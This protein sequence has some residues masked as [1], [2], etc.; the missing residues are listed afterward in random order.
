ML[1]CHLASDKRGRVA[2][3]A[4]DSTLPPQHSPKPGRPPNVPNPRDHPFAASI[5]TLQSA[6]AELNLPVAAEAFEHTSLTLLLPSG[7]FGPEPS[8][9]VVRDE[10]M[11]APVDRVSP[12]TVPALE[13]DASVLGDVLDALGNEDAGV[14]PGDTVGYWQTVVSLAG[15][16]VRGGR[17]VPHLELREDSGVAVWRALPSTAED[18]N[19]L[20]SLRGSMPPLAR[21]LVTD[22]VATR[23]EEA[24]S[25]GDADV[26]SA[27]DV[28]VRM[29]DVCVDAAVRDRLTSTEPDGSGGELDD[30]HE[31]WLAALTRPDGTI[32]A[33]PDALEDLRQQLD[34]WT[35]SLEATGEQGVRLCL[36]LWAPEPESEPESHS[37][38]D[39]EDTQVSTGDVAAVSPHGWELELLLQAADDP[40][41]LVEASTVW[42]S[43]E[44]TT[45][46]L[47]RH[48]D[49]P[50]ETLLEELGRAA[51]LYPAL[52][53]AL[54]EA[55]PTTLELTATEAN[56]FLREKAEVLEQA[57]FGVVLPAW[58]NEPERRLGAQLTAE[59]EESSSESSVGGI[60]VEQLCEFR[61]DVVL[62]DERLSKDDLEELAAL[63]MPLVRVR[64]QWV[65]L[66][67]GDI[68]NALELYNETEDGE[69]TVAEAL[70]ADTGLT[71]TDHGLP[72]VDRQFEGAL[73]DLFDTDLEA[74]IDDAGTPHGFDG[75]LRPYQKRG[76]GWLSYLEE[77]GFGGC[78]A[79]DMG[80]GKTI[81]ILA[82]LVEERVDGQSLG[83]TLVVCPLSVVGNWKHEANE[84]APQLQVYVHH[85][86]ERASGD[87]LDEA[88]TNHDMIVTTYGVVRN[89]I[90]QLRDIQFHRVIL[91]EAQKIKNTS[92][93]R[94]QAIRT[95]SARHR[96]ALTG[97]PVQN[98]LS[99]LWSI[100][101]FC[102]PGL[103]DSETAFRETFARPIE[104]YG[105]E[106][107]ADTLRRLIRPFILR[108]S[109]TDE[110]IIDDLPAKI[111]SKE[112][113]NLTEEQATLYKAATDELL[114][115]VEQASNMERR[116]KV[117]Q[118]IN[119]LKAIC[120]HPRQYHEDGSQLVG[121]S[122]KLARLEDLATEILA[123]D[124][125]ALIFTQYTSMAELLRQY[126][127]DQLGRRVLYLHGGT[128]KGKRDE[129]VE[130]FQSPDGPPL[131]LLS[132]RAG[133]TGLTL[134]AATHVIHYDR[135]WNPAV[136][137][138]AT[139][140][141]YR[142]GQ[143]DD[144]QVHKLICEG[145]VEEA[146][147]QTI[148]Q[149]RELADQVLAEGDEWITELSTDELQD[150]V[151]LSEE[152]LA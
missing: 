98:R 114:G 1:V 35:R 54:D 14:I 13:C 137:D 66:Q 84:F 24:N 58:W 15:E 36:R 61:W 30:I 34:E 113:C 123:S 125:R 71:D 110:R 87:T 116:G 45:E 46:V 124:D 85:G 22:D 78:L 75:Q 64:G 82:R 73:A 143:T 70:Q 148:E 51:S 133:G 9:E 72:V 21:A 5:E 19:R 91:D 7:R 3:W 42:K 97:T 105:D 117:L 129:M 134:T 49:R 37:D 38:A 151:T 65:S 2:L 118:L 150:L 144:V 107:K 132:L 76:L 130:R 141:T 32:D 126:L 128:P 59:S 16:L 135:W 60:G 20:Q 115:Q 101:E 23:A 145:T 81:Q 33:D 10:E 119:A 149:K 147:D 121:R 50:Q 8:P 28:L 127:Q 122:G 17:V 102:N 83:P 89:D 39:A 41:L 104:R 27:R 93:K 55:T 120:N 69:M 100:M 56:E 139:D 40:S 152:T 106:H 140:R 146:I 53:S 29:L 136:E 6:F 94:T 86:T 142:I 74:W 48:L 11:D 99:E 95:L 92:A 18:F 57:G 67:E 131:F 63:K 90:E 26:Q 12:W 68:E 108:R 52:E 31:Q 79:D 80:L 109:K 112:Y 43:T 62:G 4:E 111:E 88:L 77:F 96:F 25:W 44:A 138:Q 47:E 103:L